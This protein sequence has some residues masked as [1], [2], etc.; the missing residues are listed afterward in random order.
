MSVKV[1]RK[2]E[3]LNSCDCSLCFRLG[4]LWGYFDP[5]EVTVTGETKAFA[6]DD[7]EAWINVNFCPACSAVTSCA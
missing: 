7:I 5:T 3:D 6:R 1:T 4:V 2:P